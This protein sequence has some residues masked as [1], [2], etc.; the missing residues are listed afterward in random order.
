[1]TWE[2]SRTGFKKFWQT[3]RRKTVYPAFSQPKEGA[4][5]VCS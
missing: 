4:G 2:I 3:D 1:M 5:S